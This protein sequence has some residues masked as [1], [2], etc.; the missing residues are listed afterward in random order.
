MGASSSSSEN[1]RGGSCCCDAQSQVET[2]SLLTP[3][4]VVQSLSENSSIEE[5][6]DTGPPSSIVQFSCE[7]YYCTE[8]EC[9]MN[10]DVVRFGDLTGAAAFDFHTEDASAKA[11]RKY[12]AKT[13]S[14]GFNPGETVKTINIPILNDDSW[15]AALEF[16]VVLTRVRGAQLGKYLHRCR[17]KIIDDD[18]FPT[19]K[20]GD[21]LRQLKAHEIS[22]P[23]LMVEYLKMNMR[24]IKIR[25]GTMIML[26]LDQLKNLY[27]LIT[28]YLQL[29]LV[30]VVLSKKIPTEH[31]SGSTA[32]RLLFTGIDAA[33]RM[34]GEDSEEA[35]AE[36]EGELWIPYHRRRTALLVGIL[37]V[38]PFTFLHMIDYYRH[39]FGLNGLSKKMLQANLLRKFLN[40]K[41][42]QRARISSGDVTM[43]M[44]RDVTEVVEEGY[45][46]LMQVA[47]IL[48]KVTLAMIFILAENRFALI[49][50]IVMPV[51]MVSFL[52]MR[53]FTTISVNELMALRQNS[54]VHTVNDAV[55]N[56]RLVADFQLRSFIVETYETRINEFNKSMGTVLRVM[57]NNMYLSP[58]L[59]TIL[60]GGYMVVGSYEVNTL[61]GPLTLGTFLATINVFKEIGAELQLIYLELMAI[62]KTFG[63]LQKICNYMNLETDLVMRKE[64]NRMR[65]TS[66]KQLS[67]IAEANLAKEIARRQD[68]QHR[69]QPQD[70]TTTS[71]S[72]A[73]SVKDELVFAVDTIN[74]EIKGLNFSY[75]SGPP[76]FNNKIDVVFPQGRLYAFVGPSREGKATLMRLIGQVLLPPPNLGGYVF[77]PPHLRVLHVSQETDVLDA[78]FPTNIV[79]NFDSAVTGGLAR[80]KAICER[81]S[82][83]Q[84]FMS[85]FD[86]EFPTESTLSSPR[87]QQNVA[88]D[89][90]KARLTHTDHARLNLARAFVMN[91]E[92]LVIHKPALPFNEVEAYDI[93]KML[94]AHVEERGLEL[95]AAQRLLRRPRTVFFTSSTLAGVKSADEV[96]EVSA[97]FGAR[98]IEKVAAAA[99]AQFGSDQGSVDG[100]PD[101]RSGGERGLQ[102]F[103][104]AVRH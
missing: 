93:I 17:V 62:Q 11:G 1:S 99:A 26:V 6:E 94:R 89:R 80:V 102:S 49:P 34:L 55:L 30:D 98:K 29:Y 54:V 64:V 40:Y 65:R 15:D 60:V 83:S 12:E 35:A 74:I 68:E 88:D 31:V 58:W 46:K 23:A 14:M 67:E 38:A 91:P 79:F 5:A 47:A 22:G 72:A 95:P 27:F 39:G 100:R 76:L 52:K 96:Y 21:L 44:I 32:R 70:G 77:V 25:R 7:I 73:V 75:G 37:Y 78:P 56:Y 28:L 69:D 51:I 101:G 33:A 90:W 59:T 18:V 48:G 61:G 85:R 92:C 36:L 104:A 87:G 71:S 8:D 19:N 97:Q 53:E 42:E 66:G 2:V 4:A 45:L 57:T 84:D 10:I 63:C 9:E 16:K 81:L 43:T 82:F 20:F 13:G 103:V 50:L 24:N 41:D 86:L 3:Q